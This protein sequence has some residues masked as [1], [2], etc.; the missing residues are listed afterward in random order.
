VEEET[1][2]RM[3]VIQSEQE[4]QFAELADLLEAELEYFAKCKDMLEE[5]RDSWPSG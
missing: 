3:E 5:L 2:A 4:Q 1:A